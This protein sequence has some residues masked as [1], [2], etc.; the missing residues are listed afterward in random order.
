MFAFLFVFSR[1]SSKYKLHTHG[2]YSENL[3]LLCLL[4]ELIV[5]FILLDFVLFIISF[6]ELSK[7]SFFV[8]VS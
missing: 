2:V 4:L 1:P 6:N 3:F 7:I 8:F 5:S